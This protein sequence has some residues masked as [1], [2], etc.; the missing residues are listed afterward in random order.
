MTMF[1]L[2][3]TEQMILAAGSSSL[4]QLLLVVPYDLLHLCCFLINDHI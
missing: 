3:V 1:V 2:Y 4:A